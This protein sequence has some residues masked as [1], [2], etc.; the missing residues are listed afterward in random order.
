M[1]TSDHPIKT[2]KL[3]FWYNFSVQAK[4][5]SIIAV[6][7]G[8]I[9]FVLTV[10]TFFTNL[11][12]VENSKGTELLNYGSEVLTR[13]V[14]Q[15][16]E[17]AGTLSVLAITPQIT[18]L[19]ADGNQAHADY[20]PVKISQLDQAWK[21]N[22]EVITPLIDTILKNDTSN[23]L[24]SF[25]QQHPEQVEVFVTDQKGLNLAMTDQTSDYLQGDEGWWMSTFDQKQVF[26]NQ[27]EYD[28]S[29]KMYAVNIGVPIFDKKGKVVIGVLR[30]TLD[31][32]QAFQFLKDIRIG[33]NG[34]VILVNRDGYILSSPQPDLL[35]KPLP[36]ALNQIFQEKKSTWQTNLA[37]LGG[38]S[39]I[40]AYVP[41]GGQ[42]GE[43]LGWG[44]FLVQDADEITKSVTQ[45]LSSSLIIFLLVFILCIAFA[46][47]AVHF[48]SSP[49]QAVSSA[50]TLLSQG[51]S[52]CLAK[53]KDWNVMTGTKDELGLLKKNLTSMAD[54]MREMS[55]TASSIAQGDLTTQVTPRSEKDELGTAFSI[56]LKSLR[57]SIHQVADSAEQLA[58]A[59]D[60]LAQ[61]ASQSDQTTEQV[62]QTMQQIAQGA[63]VQT[64]SIT[65]AMKS[66]E[67]MSQAV[68]LVIR[69]TDEQAQAVEKAQTATKEMSDYI[70]QV[71][72]NAHHVQVKS[73][74]AT[75][76]ARKGY[77]IVQETT[78]GME[79]IREKVGFSGAKVQEMG[80]YSEQIGTILETIE[81][82]ASQTNLLAL[83][84]AIEAARA[85][86]QGKGFAVVADEV[87]KLAER[88]SGATQEIGKIIHEIQ[89]TVAEAVKAMEVGNHEVE[90]GVAKAK[91]A[92]KA[93][94]EVLQVS[95][96]VYQQAEQ[97]S[98]AVQQMSDS[99]SKI[100]QVFG[101]VSTVVKNN[102]SA[103]DQISLGAQ[104]VNHA[105]DNIANVSEENSA[106]VEEVSAS[107]EEMS[108]QAQEISQSARSLAG[109]AQSLQQ[110]VTA[111]TLE[112]QHNLPAPA[113]PALYPAPK[114][115][116]KN[117]K[118]PQPLP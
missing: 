3:L 2:N 5:L 7:I 24:R 71:A 85:G 76:A 19:V 113:I 14:S 62:A 47:W 93:L 9:L 94:D 118:T 69:G 23:F 11:R 50:L 82:I 103:A 30:G 79:T 108:A 61:S 21:D 64:N 112:E 27:V 100:I 15:I 104:E 116:H 117:A 44:L 73:G 37:D 59:S 31:I 53:D 99:A 81:E 66:M 8:I 38:R 90:S 16:E 72:L 91:G 12:Q 101:E 25:T 46:Y 70:S 20:D 36:K 80:S 1:K 106:A 39:A 48:I 109:M 10:S 87:R 115:G 95:E 74:E 43:K 26:I 65:G 102:I 77:Q 110:V 86:E 41:L 60:Q 28:D 45:G 51:N 22:S 6:I 97:A 78:Q 17:K 29:S 84:A 40:I 52:D 32:S 58:S 33:K 18:A 75:N 88:A 56:M 55:R 63:S 34:Y 107:A 13:M 67:Q 105:I 4:I 42:M 89:R 92:G 54:Y 35:M 68:Q 83:N 98:K 111:F 114:N 49:I 57:D 96:T